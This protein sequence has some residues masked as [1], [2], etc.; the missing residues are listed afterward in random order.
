MA[1]EPREGTCVLF[2]NRGDFSKA[3]LV[4]LLQWLV[5][6]L[7]YFNILTC[8]GI[9]AGA[10][11][12][13]CGSPTKELTGT[14]PVHVLDN[15][16]ASSRSWCSNRRLIITKWEWGNLRYLKVIFWSTR[17]D[18]STLELWSGISY[19]CHTR[20]SYLPVST[21]I[22]IIPVPFISAL[23]GFL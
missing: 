7:A 20:C 21:F 14:T 12:D 3:P 1:P 23:F 18:F 10:Y 2:N 6:S 13:G 8:S 19:R 11:F 16:S 17:T 22:L 9:S 4:Q 15:S 5:L